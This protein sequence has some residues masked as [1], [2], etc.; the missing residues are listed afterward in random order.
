V[1]SAPTPPPSSRIPRFDWPTAAVVVAGFATVLG[2]VWMKQS[3]PAIAG[4]IG[5]GAGAYLAFRSAIQGRTVDEVK[6]LANG[7]NEALRQQ[8]ADTRSEMLALSKDHAR[9]VAALAA[10]WPTDVPLPPQVTEPARVDA[11]HTVGSA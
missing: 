3:L 8:V 11:G 9:V 2:L 1:S 5:S 6:S 4:F 10:K 7:N